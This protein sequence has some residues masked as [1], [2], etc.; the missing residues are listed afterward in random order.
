MLHAVLRAIEPRQSLQS[1]L[2]HWDQ[3]RL[4]L[5]ERTRTRRP[6]LNLLSLQT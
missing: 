1:V 6:Q 2:D 4:A 5:R 3:I